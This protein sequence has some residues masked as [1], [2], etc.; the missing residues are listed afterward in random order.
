VGRGGFPH[1]VGKKDG[2]LQKNERDHSG[3][4]KPYASHKRKIDVNGGKGP[5]IRRSGKKKNRGVYGGR[6]GWVPESTQL[7]VRPVLRLGGEPY[8]FRHKGSL[9]RGKGVRTLTEEK[10]RREGGKG[11]KG[12]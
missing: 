8:L 5:A 1:N 6:R 4:K 11:V 7:I 9:K 2:S 3:G 12:Q 10:K